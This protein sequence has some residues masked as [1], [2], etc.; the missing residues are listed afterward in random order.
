MALSYA[1]AAAAIME[2]LCSPSTHGYSQVN[3]AGVGTGG[4]KNETIALS[5]GTK[6][7]ISNGD[8]DCSSAAIE[9]YAALGVPTGG[10]TYTGNMRRC[11]CGTGNFR[12]ITDLSQR[13][14][15]D[16]LLNEAHHTAVYLGGGRLGQFSISERGTT[17]GTRG[18]QTGY[19]SNVKAYYNYPWNGI[20]RYCGP[21]REGSETPSGPVEVPPTQGTGGLDLGPDLTVFGPKFA[22]AWET[23]L[24]TEV[25]GFISGQTRAD[26]RY[27]WAVQD[28]TV[29]YDS[30]TGS[31]AVTKAQGKLIAAGY[32]CGPKGADGLY[33]PS[34]IAAHQRWLKKLGYYA[35][36]IDG[37][38]G[39]DTNRAMAKA[40]AAGA[41][42]K[43]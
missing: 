24:G 26:A 40:L 41:Y 16:I 36:D 7:K 32:P 5:D 10:A 17:H 19:E 15:G 12:W 37:Y 8:R 23:Q 38:H 27:F 14:R 21:A 33:G 31:A 9:C 6:V 39:H 28:G 34:T 20:L 13:R 1:D 25:D 11:M 29:R 2:H 4:P 30:G 22:R 42:R 3:R 35:G 18:D 43:L